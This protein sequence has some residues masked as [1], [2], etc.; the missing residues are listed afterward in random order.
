MPISGR[1][2][3]PSSSKYKER[4]WKRSYGVIACAECRRFVFEISPLSAHYRTSLQAQTKMRQERPMF[5]MYTE[6][7][8]FH[9]SKWCVLTHIIPFPGPVLPSSAINTSRHIFYHT[10]RVLMID[11]FTP[12]YSPDACREP[13]DRTRY[14][15]RP[16]SISLRYG[17]TNY[18]LLVSSLRTPT[19]F[20]IRSWG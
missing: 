9:L 4:E 12:L 13:C 17:L 8:P 16:Y 15:V 1:G 18:T 20:T 7:L 2:D 10:L 14:T 3:A 6:R 11:S 5:I 19:D